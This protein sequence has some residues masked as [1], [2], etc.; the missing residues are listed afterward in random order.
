MRNCV[1]VGLIAAVCASTPA[2]AQD[3]HFWSQ[4]YATRGVLL[5]GAVIGSADDLGASFY[6]PGLM[7]WVNQRELLIGSNVY[8]Y[9]SLKA[10]DPDDSELD[11]TSSRFS[12][13]PNLVAGQFGGELF[14]GKIS[15]SL[16]TRHSVDISATLRRV[17]PG[18]PAASDLRA[19]EYFFDQSLTE[20][21]TGVTWARHL[22]EN[23][24]IGIS[25]YVAVRNQGLREQGLAQIAD[26]A[27]NVGTAL[28]VHDVRYSHWRLLAKAGVGY[29][30]DS[31]SFGM[32]VTT[33][34]LKLYGSGNTF[35]NASASNLD[36]NEDGVPD[37][38]LAS[39]FQDE[40][41]TTF[42]APWSVGAGG[43]VTF[44]RSTIH[45]S[46]EWFSAVDEYDVLAVESFTS[47]TDGVDHQLA[48]RQGLKSIVNVG[49]GIEVAVTDEQ[50]L[51]LSLVSDQSAKGTRSDSSALIATWDI[52]HA[53]VGSNVDVGIA[54][55]TVGVSYAWGSDEVGGVSSPGSVN[56]PAETVGFSD[57]ARVLFR[58][59]RMLIGIQTSF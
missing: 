11:L 9:M 16:L 40:L 32:T 49:A 14:G 41:E 35:L 23:W 51:F 31:Y 38:V 21:W 30:T 10:E 53:T 28:V 58:R 43:S 3:A 24:G 54:D 39:T 45:A 25:P 33:P 5:G 50:R 18:P 8:E 15:Y 42:K 27:G 47:Q 44:G 26:P 19:G 46:A 34:G 6:N 36:V 55:L 59:L 20:V 29:R 13:L 4:H 52:L 17:D 1:L 37:D 2:G 56:D 12:V 22:G 48:V 57:E 7:A